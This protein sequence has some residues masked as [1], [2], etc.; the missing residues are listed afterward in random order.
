MAH[1]IRKTTGPHRG[2]IESTL[3]NFGTFVLII[4]IL[5][6]IAAFFISGE[7]T[8]DSTYDSWGEEGLS[9]FWLAASIWIPVQGF[10]LFLFFNWTS[11][12]VC[13]LKKIAGLP[14]GVEISEATPQ[15]S[16]SCS[17]CSQK[18]ESYYRQCPACGAVLEGIVDEQENI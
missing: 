10:A 4:S 7:V 11:Q 14:C 16:Y 12:V 8:K 6:A 1:I 13:L 9:P 5:A 3:K 2:G 18:V 17:Q 15:I